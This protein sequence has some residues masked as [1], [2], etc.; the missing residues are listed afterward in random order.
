MNASKIRQKFTIPDDVTYLN[1]SYM[2][3]QL[4]AATERAIEEIRRKETP[5]KYNKED[6]FIHVESLQKKI[7]L[8][9]DTQPE[10]VALTPSVSYGVSTA[11]R[12]VLHYSEPGEILMLDQQFPSNVYPW[13]ALESHG[14]SI[15]V[16]Q[17][18]LQKDLTEQVLNSIG[19]STK[20]VTVG[21]CHWADGHMMDI[22]K[23]GQVCRQKGVLFV[24]DG[25]QSVGVLPTSVK[26]ARVHYFAGGMYKWLLGPYGLS[27]LFVDK[28]FCEGPALDPTWMSRVGSDDFTQLT[29]YNRPLLPGA[30]RY[31]MGGKSSFIHV[32]IANTA[33]QF[34][35][36]LGIENICRE[37]RK[38]TD[39][40]SGYFSSRGMQLIPRDYRAPHIL[41]IMGEKRQWSESFQERLYQRQVYV[42][43]RG[44]CMRISPNVF[45][46]DSDL[47]R[48]T[49]VLDEVL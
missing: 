22:E 2:G 47:N 35:L 16:L 24:V 25:I 12:G 5:W 45:N 21:Q 33:I 34:L 9:L 37:V 49:E 20:V 40:L 43:F 18:N 26:K 36:E 10:Q 38:K 48:L 39:F 46:T 17:R 31:H 1:C 29:N 42:S 13:M 23:V 15:K 19:A 14:F 11:A 7:A 28:D 8:L 4:K 44:D 30:D 27:Y 32:A 3:P 6:F 41:S